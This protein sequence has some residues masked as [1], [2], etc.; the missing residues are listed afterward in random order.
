[1][2]SLLSVSVKPGRSRLCLFKT[3]SLM[4][5]A[6]LALFLAFAR[7]AQAQIYP[8]GGSGGSGYPGSSNWVPTDAQGNRLPSGSPNPS[9]LIPGSMQS[10]DKNTYPSADDPNP[11]WF[12]APPPAAKTP[13]T[14]PMVIPAWPRHFQPRRQLHP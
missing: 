2:F 14:A 12:A 11:F 6:L 7:P 5:L 10:D 8:G 4:S 1:M 3:L 9:P 13:A